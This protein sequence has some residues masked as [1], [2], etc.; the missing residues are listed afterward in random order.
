V[1]VNC[2][3]HN[4][5]VSRLQVEEESPTSVEGASDRTVTVALE[6]QGTGSVAKLAS[7]LVDIDGVVSVNAGDV[8]VV[9]D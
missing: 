9:T 1:L 6:I 8:N 7:K 2:T 4:L 3:Q 5:A